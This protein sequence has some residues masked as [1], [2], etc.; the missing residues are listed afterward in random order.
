MTRQFPVRTLLCSFGLSLFALFQLVNGYV[1][2]GP[3]GVI[4]LLSLLTVAF[5]VKL[6]QYQVAVY[7]HRT[8]TT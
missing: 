3:L 2:Q 1:H 4:G 5:S 6:T 7:R 8:V